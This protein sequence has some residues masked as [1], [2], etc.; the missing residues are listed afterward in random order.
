MPDD[1]DRFF[2]AVENKPVGIEAALTEAVKHGRALIESYRT[3][4]KDAAGSTRVV[5]F[6]DYYNFYPPFCQQAR[7]R[8]P[9]EP[10]TNYDDII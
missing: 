10:P 9:G 2:Q 7:C 5:V 3:A 1:I 8:Q 4:F 6:I